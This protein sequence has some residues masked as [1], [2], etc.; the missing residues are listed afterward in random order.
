MSRIA[1]RFAVAFFCVAL[2]AGPIAARPLPSAPDPRTRSEARVRPLAADTRAHN[3]FSATRQEGA[4][5]YLASTPT[6]GLNAEAWRKLDQAAEALPAYLAKL[7]VIPPRV[8][9]DGP[10]MAG[11]LVAQTQRL[12]LY[13][14]AQ[15]FTPEQ[16]GELAPKLEQLLRENEERFGTR[17][18]QRVSVA[19]YRAALAPEK[20]VRGMA[21]TGEGRAEIF[22]RPGEDIDRASVVAAHEL[23][24]H[25]EAAR[26]GNDAQRRA[27]TV[28]HEGLATWLVGEHWLAVCSQAGS[29]KERAQQL[30]AAGIPMRLNTAETFGANNA[31]EMWA[32]FV[33]F[34]I[35]RYG[36]ETFDQ[37]YASGRGRAHGSTN[38]T[39]VLGKPLDDVADEWRAWLSE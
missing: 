15:T 31:Y 24:H 12:D 14:G 28:L 7:P 5:A 30:R 23:G 4:G 34:L 6:R 22:Y 35:E 27:D 2:F 17:L 32:S 19:F 20:G 18:K 10:R 9:G 13:V 8:P 25:L 21:Y 3:A 39:G 1:R 11:T 26:Y 36:W 37:L 16:I 33:E 38:Y 29:W